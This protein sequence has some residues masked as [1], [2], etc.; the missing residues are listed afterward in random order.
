MYPP[1]LD[2]TDFLDVPARNVVV[3]ILAFIG[4]EYSRSL[5]SSCVIVLDSPLLPFCREGSWCT[6]RSLIFPRRSLIPNLY[7]LL[8]R[9]L[10]KRFRVI[11]SGVGIGCS[12]LR[13]NPPLMRV[14]FN[15]EP[16]N[17]RISG[18]FGGDDGG[19]E[20]GE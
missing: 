11:S 7:H 2:V 17:E 19:R 12:R 5:T 6:M 4:G 13:H 15:G 1:I 10:P 3:C 20:G 14:G 9:R 18:V 8:P 16:I